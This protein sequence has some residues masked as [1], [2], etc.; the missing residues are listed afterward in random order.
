M[1]A[2]VAFAGSDVPAVGVKHC[3]TAYEDGAATST[4]PT[5]SSP[6]CTSKAGRGGFKRATSLRPRAV[7]ASSLPSLEL[8]LN[9]GVDTSPTPAAAAQELAPRTW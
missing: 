4:R 3:R 8:V 2:A 6:G 5:P 1:Q 7:H 9:S